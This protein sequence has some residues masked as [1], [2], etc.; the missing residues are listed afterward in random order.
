MINDDLTCLCWSL[1]EEYVTGKAKRV[2]GLLRRNLKQCPKELR[3]MSYFSIKIFN[4]L[5]LS[6]Q[7]IFLH[8]VCLQLI[9]CGLIKMY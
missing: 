1:D 6:M 3:K 5:T 9:P 7:Y 8:Q 2:C 4:Q